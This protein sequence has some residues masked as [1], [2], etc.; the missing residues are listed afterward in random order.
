MLVGVHVSYNQRVDR[1]LLKKLFSNQASSRVVDEL[2][3]RRGELLEQGRLKPKELTATIMF[4]DLRGFAK[5]GRGTGSRATD[6]LDQQLDG[7]DIA[8]GLS[9]SWHDQAVHRGR[10]HG[11]VWRPARGTRRRGRGCPRGGLLRL[12]MRRRIAGINRLAR[13]RGQLEIE[14]RIG[15]CTGSLVAGSIGG[16][17]RTEY[18][19]IGD[20]VNL[21]S[22][23]ESFEKDLPTPTLLPVA[24][25]F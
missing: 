7:S 1:L 24:A 18:T 9:V 10:H 21:A 4:T 8:A 15:I 16:R 11:I 25:A 2:W 17:E 5:V 19:V 22:R 14:M 3:D 12:A 20:T 13:L 23:L 6:R